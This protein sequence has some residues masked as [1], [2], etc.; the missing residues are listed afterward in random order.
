MEWFKNNRHVVLLEGILLTIL[1]ILAIAMPG[2]ST[3]STEL[4]IGWLL[5]FSGAIQLYRTFKS[6]HQP[7]FIGSV[8]LSVMYIAFG[9]LL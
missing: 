6:R 1:G 5:F 4:F 8:L 9:L 3:L 2:I 7:G